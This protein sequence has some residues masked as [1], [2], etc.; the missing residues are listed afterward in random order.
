MYTPEE[1][2][3]YTSNIF[4]REYRESFARVVNDRRY[5]IER[6]STVDGLN[7][8]PSK[9]NF[10]FAELTDGVSGR[11]LRDRLIK[12]YGI[13]V[14]ECSNKMGAGEQYLRLAVQTKA[15]VD[16][17]IP[18]LRQEIARACDGRS[19]ISAV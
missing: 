2:S 7:V 18:A 4:Q 3:P 5:L 1:I 10:V 19:F 11:S 14:R 12:N 6:L 16:V 9:A 8:Y 17:L 15:A 13:M